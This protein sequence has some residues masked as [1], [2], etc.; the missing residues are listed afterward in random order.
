M[1]FSPSVRSISRSSLGTVCSICIASTD[2]AVNF[3]AWNDAVEEACQNGIGII[4]QPGGSMRDDDTVECC[5]KYGV[6]LV[7]T[8]VRHFRH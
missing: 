5:N 7:V 1:P 6:L 4:V 2:W 8:G 3:T